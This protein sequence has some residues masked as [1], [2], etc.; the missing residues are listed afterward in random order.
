[1]FSDT[2]TESEAVDPAAAVAGSNRNNNEQL[3]PTRDELEEQESLG[4]DSSDSEIDTE[5]TLAE[6][7]GRR[8]R[9]KK[10][11]RAQKPSAG[12]C[13][14]SPVADLGDREEAEA[15][16]EDEVS[17]G[18][19]TDEAAERHKSRLQYRRLQSTTE[20]I[21]LLSPSLLELSPDTTSP[22]PDLEQIDGDRPLDSRGAG[23][24]Q[25][26]A[27]HLSSSEDE[28]EAALLDSDSDC[29]VLMTQNEHT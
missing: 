20:E 9:Q 27:R 26:H 3:P 16:A 19:H 25:Q 18:E 29:V 7:L 2:D 13:I 4:T 5:Q 14:L 6:R 21:S 23:S 11:R 24:T 8:Q 1:M 28:D 17:G 10:R 22:E 12:V 15:V